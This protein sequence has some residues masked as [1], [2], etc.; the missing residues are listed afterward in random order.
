MRDERPYS[1][2]VVPSGIRVSSA[3]GGRMKCKLVGALLCAGAAWAAYSRLREPQPFKSS[4]TN[5][6]TK[7]LIV[8]GGFGGLAAARELT[9]TLGGSEDVGVALLDQVN[10]TTF[11]PMVPSA[12]P[13]N[14]EVRHVAHSIRRIFAPLGVEF[15]QE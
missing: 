12:I 5:A 2:K 15:F 1:T 11:W 10:Y 6:P 3:E 9:R 14:V 13:R 7:I 4:Y 8:G